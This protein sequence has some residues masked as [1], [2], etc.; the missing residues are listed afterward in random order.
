MISAIIRLALRW[1]G[2]VLAIVVVV[3]IVGGWNLAQLPIDAVPDITNNQVQV[4][5]VAPAL[6]APDVERLITFPI[7]QACSNIPGLIELRSFSRFGLSV[8]TLVFEDDVD[9]YW[10]RQ[11]INERL[12]SVR[13]Q[14]PAG[15]GIPELAPVTTGLGEILQYVVRPKPGY[16]NRYRLDELRTIQDWIIRRQ[17]L[18]TPGVADV[19]SFGGLLRQYEISVHPDRLAAYGLTLS[20]IAAAVERNSSNAGGAYIERGPTV[21][22]IRTEGF[23]GSIE[24]IEQIPVATNGTVPI[25]VRDVAEVRPAAAIRYGAM[26]YNDAGEVAGAVVMMLKGE[27]SSAVV[28]RVKARLVEIERTLPEGVTI[29]PFLDRTK[30]VRATIATVRTNL[31]EG[32]AIVVLVLILL[33]GNIPAALIVASVIPLSFLIA[34]TLMRA[35]GVSG[36]LMSLGAL[37]FGL[38]VDGAVIIVEA[39][40]HRLARVLRT[41]DKAAIVPLV[42]QTSSQLMRAAVFGQLIILIV[43][44]PVLTLQGIEGKMFRPMALVL[45]YALGGAFL[46][47]MTYVP[48]LVSFVFEHYRPP[49]RTFA[50]RIVERIE[51]FYRPL[52]HGALRKPQVALA[53]SVLLLGGAAYAATTLGGEFLPK[54]EEGDFAVDTRL[55][56]G[57]SLRATVE[58]TQRC[59][60]I[61]RQS[62]PEVEKVVTK[63]G[64]A[65]IPTDPMPIEASDM[66]VILKPKH[67]WTTASSYDELAE[68]MQQRL[69]AAMPGVTFGFQFPVQMR[70]NELMTGARQDVVCK[71]FGDDL[72]TLAALADRIAAIAA[73]IDGVRDIYRERMLGMPQIVVRYDR[74]RLAQ[75]GISIEDANTAITAAFAGARV[76][77]FY[78]GE[79]RF[80]V[81]VRLDSSVRSDPQTIR[82]LPLRSA[83]G[84]IVPLEMV[85]DIRAEFGPNQIQRESARRRIVVGFNVRG[86]DVESVVNE[87]EQRIRQSLRLPAGYEIRYGGTFENLLHARARLAISV[88]LAIGAIFIL[89][90]A[91]FGKLR[92]ALLI[93]SAVPLAAIGGIAALVVRQLHFSVSAGV[94]FIALFGVAV[95]N[96]VVLVSEFNRRRKHTHLVRAIAE[97]T[98]VRFR[99]VLLTA[100]VASL[101]FLPMALSTSPGAEVQRPLATV[102]IGGLVSATFLTLVLVPVLYLLIER[103]REQRAGP[104]LLTA[105]A[106]ICLVLALSDA[107]AIAQQPISLGQ[108]M[109]RLDSVHP[110]RLRWRATVRQYDYERQGWLR[111]SPLQVSIEYGQYNTAANDSRI[112]VYLPLQ[113]PQ[114]Y[115]ASRAVFEQQ[116]LQAVWQDQWNSL[117]RRAEL[118]RTAYSAQY[119][120]ELLRLLEV[121]DSLYAR[122]EQIATAQLNRG[123]ATRAQQATIALQ[124]GTIASEYASAKAAYTAALELF[125]RFLGYD[126][127]AVVPALDSLPIAPLPLVGKAHPLVEHA[128]ARLDEQRAQRDGT[129]A[130]L[131]LPTIGIGFN[132]TTL[133]GYQNV[134]G[135]ERYYGPQTRFN[136][137]TATAALPLPTPWSAAQLRAADERVRAAEWEYRSATWELETER[138]RARRRWEQAYYLR[139]ELERRVLP[140]AR[141]ILRTADA[142][143]RS[144]AVG[145]LDWIVS[146]Q[147][148]FAVQRAYLDALRE[149]NNATVEQYL[150]GE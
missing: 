15:T 137:L 29:E 26:C 139:T 111:L 58:T 80:D 73:Q 55:L 50:D 39:V 31:L 2:A 11:Q 125:N 53:A 98:H 100:A 64:S 24:D 9:T 45:I 120:R 75:Y 150:L 128:Q 6:G 7:E 83:T 12:S 88:P 47:S 134:T 148:A 66:M 28:N 146:I 49:E 140:A 118:L 123:A 30:M 38:L 1:R 108:A 44:V 63:I 87:L 133:I 33:L 84:A 78:E 19:A 77:T 72:D 129:Y 101:G 74:S 109:A 57:S 46:L 21:A 40:L 96:G 70:F 147:S 131:I 43:Y 79:R 92:H 116:Y 35:T 104:S 90:Y 142:E 121:M 145:F 136:W 117:Q 102:V 149:W 115:T 141:Q 68:K 113:L 13:L 37:D 27:N 3:A 105:G 76:G 48:A 10:A 138:L 65:E 22:F 20:D 114:A 69:T 52:L 16:E 14:L 61:L 94:G 60:R 93:L 54:L 126:T 36:N 127:I 95:L 59:A 51:R 34:A 135:V 143:L 110:D 82:T 18:G 89:L 119:W 91:A 107:P 99:P 103:R 17:L 85:A 67:T 5:T 71:I 106:T 32:A 42:E 56:T 132:S 81:V 25:L 144:G 86:R 124:R 4:L 97:A 62:F 112:G 41:T 23:I 130:A 8:I 122:A